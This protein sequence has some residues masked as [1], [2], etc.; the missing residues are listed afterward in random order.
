MTAQKSIFILLLCLFQFW[1]GLDSA[2]R[3]WCFVFK[4]ITD[5]G[6][7]V[8]EWQVTRMVLMIY[9]MLFLETC[10]VHCMI[11]IL[12][13]WNNLRNWLTIS[14]QGEFACSFWGRNKEIVDVHLRLLCQLCFPRS[15]IN[16][17]AQPLGAQT[18]GKLGHPSNS[19]CWGRPSDKVET[20]RTCI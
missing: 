4:Y 11:S 10:C 1:Q 12:H 19:I 3:H 20:S 13:H 9:L 5:L 16:Y 8:R 15:R 14:T 18:N 17:Q 2:D 6:L 7:S